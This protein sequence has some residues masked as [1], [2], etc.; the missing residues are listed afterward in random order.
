VIRGGRCGGGAFTISFQGKDSIKVAEVTNGLAS[1]FIT[2]NLKMR[3]SQAI[4]SSKFLADELESVR[5]RLAEKEDELKRYRTR[6][7]G[8]L[9]EQL[10]TNLSILSRL[11]TQVDQYNENLT[12]ISQG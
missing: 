7:M 12:Q 4:G 10:Q 5:K 3:E 6:Y 9:P 2:E 1:N 11:Q 8:G